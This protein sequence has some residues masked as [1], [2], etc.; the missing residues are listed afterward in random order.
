MAEH[1]ESTNEVVW[2][3]EQTWATITEQDARA[4]AGSLMFTN[5][6]LLEL[7]LEDA[8]TDMPFFSPQLQEEVGN[9]VPPPQEE[10]DCSWTEA[11]SHDLWYDQLRQQLYDF[12]QG[13]ECTLTTTPLDS[14]RRKQVHSMSN[15]WGLSH[16]SVGSGKLKRVLLSKCALAKTGNPSDRRWNPSRDAWLPGYIDP[17]LV[18]FHWISSTICFQTCLNVLQLPRPINTIMDVRGDYGTV[19]A[20]FETPSDAASALLA[21]HG[22]RPHWNVNAGDRNIEACYLRLPFGFSLTSHLLAAGFSRLPALVHQAFHTSQS[23][24]PNDPHSGSVSPS[25][26]ACLPPPRRSSLAPGTASPTELAN[27]LFRISS[28]PRQYPPLS[29]SALHSRRGSV[30]R[31]LSLSSSLSRDLG[32]ISASSQ[33]DSEYSFGTNASKKRRRAPKVPGGYPCA[34]HGCDKVFDHQG[35]LTKHEKVHGTD[36]PH[37]CTQCGKGFS[38]P[39]DLRRHERTHTVES[40]TVSPILE[41]ADAID[42]GFD[43]YDTQFENNNVEAAFTTLASDTNTGVCVYCGKGFSNPPDWGI[44]SQHLVTCHG[45]ESLLPPACSSSSSSHQRN[46]PSF[47]RI[48]HSA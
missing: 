47:A 6:E 29:S 41:P 2:S 1:S 45:L 38:Y 10:S 21:L 22:A 31:R 5:E 26:P 40:M 30:S 27:A 44:R 13:P 9:T 4:V 14:R 42:D 23:R 28:S 19:Y 33:V 11:E 18:L 8:N 48:C 20:L 37:V 25:I 12:R 3:G 34:V 24:D 39:K 46:T 7:S 43:T 15:L 36:R 17:R 35:E 16:M 32:Y